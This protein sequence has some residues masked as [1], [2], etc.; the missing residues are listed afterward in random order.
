MTTAGLWR[1][2]SPTETIQAVR[3]SW[4]GYTVRATGRLDLDAL[5][6]AYEAVWRAYPQLG[7]RLETGADG[8]GF[9]TSDARPELGVCDGDLDH[10]MTGVKLDQQ[11]ALSAL[12]VVRDGDDDMSVCL[13]THHSIADAHHSIEVLAALW[14]CYTDVVNGVPVE[15]PRHPFPRSLEDLLAERGIHATAPAAGATSAPP[16]A[17]GQPVPEPSTPARHVVQHRLTAAET[18]ALAE[19]GHREH[20]TVNGLLAG[21]LLLV[22][23]ELRDLP[24]T[25]LMYRFT[26]NLRRHLTPPVGATEGTNVLGGAG[27]SATEDIEPDAVAIGRAVGTRL[28]AG[29][30][31]GS[32]QR[33]LLDLMSRPAPD[34]RPWNPSTAPVVVSMIN[35]GLVPPLRTPDGLRL[36]NFRSASRIFREFTLLGG[37]VVN[38]FDG[39]TGIDLA[40]PEG[41]PELPGRIDCLRDH[42]SGVTR[43]L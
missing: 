13:L 8:F 12:N 10:P 40:W 37:Y 22:E 28:R 17:T 30:A 36:T 20:V 19:L 11:R 4:I 15:L 38:T 41:D 6:T 32:I 26:V 42:V 27:F 16:A 2:L 39:R 18:S 24:F 35:W 33:S 34:A 5:A 29:L 43:R 23:A 21:I 1:A 14:S 31:D 3:E 9:A 7:A 25:D